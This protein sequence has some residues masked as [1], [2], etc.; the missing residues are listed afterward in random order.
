MALQTE[1]FKQLLKTDIVDILNSSIDEKSADDAVKNDFAT[2]LA[3]AIGDRLD[4]WIKTGIVTVQP[5]IPV[6]TAGT[7]TAQTG[8]TVGP[9]T[10]TIS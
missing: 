5:G 6:T 8:S 10:G 7:P 4:A 1:L 2:K 9:G 3:N